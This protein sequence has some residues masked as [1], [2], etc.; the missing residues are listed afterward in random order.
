LRSNHPEQ[1]EGSQQKQFN[2]APLAGLFYCFLNEEVMQ[3]LLTLANNFYSAI[4]NR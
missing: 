1:S 2:L 3:H 4:K